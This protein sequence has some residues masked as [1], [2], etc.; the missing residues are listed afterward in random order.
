MTASHLL[1][2]IATV[3][4]SLPPLPARAQQVVGTLTLD[5][6]S[7]VSFDNRTTLTI[8]SGASLRFHFA[9]P[10]ADGSVA[11]TL[12]PA[13]VSIPPI[14]L[15]DGKSTLTYR[16]ATATTGTLRPA[17]T[18]SI[19]FTASLS[20]TL[21]NEQ[22]SST[23]TY[24]V[25]F[26][27]HRATATNADGT[28]TIDVEGMPLVDGPNHVQLVGATTNRTDAYRDPGVATYAVLSGTFDELPRLP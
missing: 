11:F 1:P 24:V 10:G 19:E 23:A 4:F 18:R 17:P 14:V 5:G 2:I 15:D 13:D 8:P 12:A 25:R 9:R 3:L 22:G 28:R 20:T 21:E 6:L 27:T 16:L 7:F 26:T